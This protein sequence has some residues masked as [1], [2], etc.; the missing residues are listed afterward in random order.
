M[1]SP[2]P[3]MDPFIEI[4]PRWELFHA[5]FIRKIAEQSL[6]KAQSLGC[7]IDVERSI[8][9]RTPE[10]GTVLL[11][12]PDH[13]AWPVAASTALEESRA[14]SASVAL[15]EPQAIHEV[16]L[17]PD[18]LDQVKQDYLVVRTLGRFQ[19]V[20]AVV[21]LL[22]PANKE[23]TYVPRFLEKRQRFL[24]A[25]VHYMEIDLLRDG[26]SPSRDV[27]PEFSDAS[28]LIYVAR[29]TGVGRND[30]GYPLRLQDALPVIGLPLGPPRPDLPLDLAAAFRATYDLSV[31][32]G[33]IAYA[34]ETVPP[35]A[36]NKAD[37]AWVRQPVQRPP[38]A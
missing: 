15:A 36:L 3:G 22:S 29:K 12:Q 9:Q 10:G 18:E 28:Y 4:N 33:S 14:P 1:P 35:P 21:E 25:Q 17:D 30:E 26:D 5:W 16:I 27:F 37:A 31:P 19:R 24:Y 34:E 6:P 2:F 7:W 23:G 8:Y 38:E 13:A 32:P 11:G 20:L